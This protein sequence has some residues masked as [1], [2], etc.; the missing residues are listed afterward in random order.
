MMTKKQKKLSKSVTRYMNKPM[1]NQRFENDCSVAPANSKDQTL[2]YLQ[3]QQGTINNILD[4]VC[5]YTLPI[6]TDVSVGDKIDILLYETG[7]D[8]GQKSDKKYSG[9]W[10]I[11]SVAHHFLLETLAAYT[12]VSCIRATNQTDE[13][14]AQKVSLVNN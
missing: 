9:K 3:Q 11:S 14:S 10:I 12:R 6:R 2:K 8:S 13:S 4:G 5:Q 1:S 7:V